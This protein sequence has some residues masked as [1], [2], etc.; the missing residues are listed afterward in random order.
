[1]KKA[2]KIVIGMRTVICHLVFVLFL[3]S[4][5]GCKPKVSGDTEAHQGMLL[6]EQREFG[7]AIPLL[8]SSLDKEL[9]VYT[10]SMVLTSIGNCYN[11]LEDFNS[12][13]QF[14]DRAIAADAKNHQAYVN[15][16]VVHRLQGDYARAEECYM[17]ALALEPN[18][19]ELHASMGALAMFQDDTE[20]AIKH[21]EKAV[22][23]DDTL[24]VAHSNLAIAYATIG[25]FKEADSELRKAVIR[26]YH[27]PD[28]VRE[29]IEMLRA[30]Q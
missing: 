14:H 1:M 13:L 30:S 9:K 4:I 21:L 6:I 22:E 3:A 24:A 5:V 26:G 20:K 2:G 27:Q 19:A 11:E 23:L 15:K 12:S 16:G 8:E 10:K 25:K 18:Y 7:K 17:K 29:H 28:A